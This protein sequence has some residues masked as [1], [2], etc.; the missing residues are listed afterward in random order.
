MAEGLALALVHKDK[1]MEAHSPVN[2]TSN[3]LLNFL[4]PDNR[5]LLAPHLERVSMMTR[6]VLEPPN[7][8]IE[9]INFPE[10]GVASVVGA[11]P[12]MGE[13]EIGIIGRKG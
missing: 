12:S 9:H 6:K 2:T 8:E 13:H 3:R 10:D 4:S 1:T 11:S 5:A 7:E